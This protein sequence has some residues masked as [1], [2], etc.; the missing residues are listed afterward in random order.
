[1]LCGPTFHTLSSTLSLD[2]F[3]G[4][5]SVK[6]LLLFSL[7][8]IGLFTVPS[9]YVAANYSE[10][11]SVAYFLHSFYFMPS[12]FSHII[13]FSTLAFFFGFAIYFSI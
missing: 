1:M 11:I 13:I 7:L 6:P 5:P 3:M 2:C 8:Y 10:E 12:L 9:F 4:F